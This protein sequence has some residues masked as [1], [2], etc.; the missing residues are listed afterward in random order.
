MMTRMRFEPMTA[1]RAADWLAFFD[2]TAFADNPEWSGCYCRVFEFPHDTE[3]WSEA[4]AN[5]ANRP[6]MAEAAA[7]GKVHGFLAYEDG[8]PVGW[9]RAGPRGMYRD[10]HSGIRATDPA[11]DDKTIAAVCFVIAAGHRRKGV[12]RGLL[13]AACDD[14]RARGYEAVEGYALKD[15]PVE[16]GLPPEAEL[17]RGPRGLFDS[18]GFAVVAETDRYWIMRLTLVPSVGE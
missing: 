10:G 14:A 12:S 16:P 3:D 5:N 15:V 4:C 9:C 7:A 8:A 2:N 13:Q 1:E 6:V 18:L 17:F 11:D